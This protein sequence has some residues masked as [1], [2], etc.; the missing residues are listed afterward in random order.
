MCSD[1]KGG[2]Y[3]S[4]VV[5][6]WRGNRNVLDVVGWVFQV[7]LW[8]FLFILAARPGEAGGAGRRY[9]HKDDVLKQYD[10]TLYYEIEERRR[11]GD[12]LPWYMGGLIFGV[13]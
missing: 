7:F 3:F 1:G 12:R 8:G 9:L 10:G 13:L 6:M 4:D 11:K 2:L 5:T